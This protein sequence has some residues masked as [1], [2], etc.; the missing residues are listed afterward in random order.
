[1]D[2]QLQAGAKALIQN[3]KFVAVLNFGLPFENAMIRRMLLR[4]RKHKRLRVR[5]RRRARRSHRDAVR[6][7]L[8]LLLL[9]ALKRRSAPGEDKQE[10]EE[11]QPSP[12]S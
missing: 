10:G 1:L 4:H 11:Q 8:G 2:R 6:A 9:R 12:P 7:R 3:K 5:G